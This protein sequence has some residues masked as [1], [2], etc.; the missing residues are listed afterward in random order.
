MKVLLLVFA[1]AHGSQGADPSTA[2]TTAPCAS[3]LDAVFDRADVPCPG[4]AHSPLLINGNAVADDVKAQPEGLQRDPAIF[5][6]EL[7]FVSTVMA[8][9]GGALVAGAAVQDPQRLSGSELAVRDGVII[10]GVSVLS[11]AGLVAS[12]ALSTW[13][14]DPSTATLRLPLF[15]GEPR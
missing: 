15:E 5:P 7:A 6:G 10:G 1:M 9:A 11:V 14:F 2:K 4:P 12:A 8:L 3:E 13:I